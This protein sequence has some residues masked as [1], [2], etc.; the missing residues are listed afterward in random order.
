MAILARAFAIIAFL[1][2]LLIVPR[3]TLTHPN[4]AALIALRADVVRMKADVA[5]IEM[6]NSRHVDRI[7]ALTN[8]PQARSVR[9]VTAYGLVR[10]D[11]I[12]IRF[13]ETAE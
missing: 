9:A 12:V 5:D 2:L 1:T 10:P 4:R 8:S 6:E 7:L 3:W 11:E 13:E